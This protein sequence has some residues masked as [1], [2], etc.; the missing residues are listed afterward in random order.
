MQH[1]K[2]L[3]KKKCEENCHLVSPCRQHVESKENVKYWLKQRSSAVT[4]KD[5]QEKTD[6]MIFSIVQQFQVSDQTSTRTA[7]NKTGHKLKLALKEKRRDGRKELLNL[8]LPLKSKKNVKP[9]MD[10]NAINDMFLLYLVNVCALKAEKSLEHVF[11]QKMGT[12]WH[13]VNNI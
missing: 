2:M 8:T 4:K 11:K 3:L 7:R 9:H 10:W 5:K 6:K 12:R 1:H 13:I